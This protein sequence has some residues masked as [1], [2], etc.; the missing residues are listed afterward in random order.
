LLPH[1]DELLGVV[2][3]WVA[4]V[5]EQ[6]FEDLLSLRRRTFSRFESGER[7]PIGAHLR[8]LG[9]A[10][11]APASTGID[12]VRGRPAMQLVARLLGLEVSR[13]ARAFT[14]R[15]RPMTGKRT[16]VAAPGRTVVG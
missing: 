7:R 5:P 4:S 9:T 11:S 6:V 16:T 13:W 14:S 8:N 2:D 10:R 15:Y 3:A 12:V 1:D